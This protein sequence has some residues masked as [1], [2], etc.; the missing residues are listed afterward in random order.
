MVKVLHELA[1]LDGGGV[2]RLLHDYYS[3]MDHDKIHFDFLI[4]DDIPDG[5]L[6]KPLKDMG[7]I[8]Y[9]IPS[10]KK[11]IKLRLKRMD[12]IIR[13][14][15][16][17]VVHSHISAR[18]CFILSI[19]KKYGIKKRYVHSHIAYQN[20]SKM[21]LFIDKAFLA[22]SK[23]LAT[24]LF[25]CGEDAGRYMWGEKA[26]SSGKV[27]IMRNAVDT[28]A[29]RFD[30]SVRNKYRK[31]LNLDDKKVLGIVG[32]L[33]YQKNHDFLLDIFAE[34]EKIDR[35]E[36]KLLIVGR[37]PYE[38][39]LREKAKNLGIDNNVEFMGI[40][41]DVS[42]LLNV[43]D[44]FILPSFFEGLPVV[45]VE[46]QANGVIEIA[47]DMITKEMAVTDLITFLSLKQTAKEWA[48]VICREVGSDVDR[49]NY[50]TVVCN[51]GYD[52]VLESKKMQEFYLK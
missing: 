51:K 45:L 44:V 16:Y 31:E 35:D 32:R 15:Q 22:Y 14:G 10:L 43:V 1:N 3:H 37:G 46:A 12:E 29:F 52:I 50:A 8:V 5:I 17:D 23:I 39:R 4:S 6:E 7:C 9:K 27:R 28:V 47:S 41:S 11:D 19:A 13:Y 36:Y 18:S 30:E 48:E 24:Q 25:A 42:K 40:R 49:E 21:K 38:G 20:I 2:A 26:V 34:I 33:D